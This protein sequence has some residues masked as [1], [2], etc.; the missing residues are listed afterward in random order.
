MHDAEHQD[1]AVF[2]DGVVHDTIAADAESV[3]GIAHS[4]D[5]LDRLAANSTRLRGVTSQ[6]LERFLD[7]RAELRRKVLERSDG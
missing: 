4:L 1:Y 2:V 5:R 7:S 6:L 3:E